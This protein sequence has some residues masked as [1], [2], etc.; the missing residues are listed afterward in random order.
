MLNVR[1]VSPTD[2]TEQIFLMFHMLWMLIV[3]SPRLS[4]YM[5]SV[6]F[7]TSIKTVL[8]LALTHAISYTIT[9]AISF[10]KVAGLYYRISLLYFLYFLCFVLVTTFYSFLV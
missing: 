5:L 6:S 2:V 9:Y 7:D 10:I 4:G 1:I 8:K 3:V